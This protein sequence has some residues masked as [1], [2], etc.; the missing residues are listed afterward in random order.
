MSKNNKKKNVRAKIEPINKN[1]ALVEAKIKSMIKNG[2]KEITTIN[3]LKNF[4]IGSLISYM[5]KFG[6]YKS[7][8]F[9][10]K[11][12]DDNFIYL[13]LETNQKFRV[14][15]KNVDKI[16]VG[17]VYDV[18]NDIVSLIQTTTKTK[19][20]KPVKIGDVIVYHAKDNYDY[21][22]YICTQ[23]YKLMKKWYETFN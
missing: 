7:G 18:K 9:L 12:T 20:S 4:L 19:N 5:N 1:K 8:G 11:I 17:N 23:K 15:M 6:I 16:W 3:E 22:R 2:R 10:W 14:K 21:E 13:N